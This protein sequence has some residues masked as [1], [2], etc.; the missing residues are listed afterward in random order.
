MERE[1]EKL[2]PSMLKNSVLCAIVARKYDQYNKEVPL[3]A[4]P[5]LLAS[6]L[7]N[8]AI[9]IETAVHNALRLGVTCK[10]LNP[11]YLGTLL[12]TYPIEDRNAVMT[13]L[14]R[15]LQ[16]GY[17]C[18]RNALQLLIHAQ[19]Q[20]NVQDPE[21]CY[22]HSTLLYQASCHNDDKMVQLLFTFGADPHENFQGNP[23]FWSAKN[24]R[25][26]QLFIAQGIDLHTCGNNNTN[27]LWE[28]VWKWDAD[29]DLMKFYLEREVN[30]RLLDQD[31]GGSILHHVI[32][33][34]NIS[35]N[36]SIDTRMSKIKLLLST[37]PDMVNVR[38]KARKTPLDCARQ[39]E[40]SQEVI[41]LFRKHGA[42]TS[43]ELEQE[44]KTYVPS[45]D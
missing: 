39:T 4:L 16:C 27:V 25:M 3:V 26:L 40:H 30:P 20:P 6:V 28:L 36:H 38:D 19:A 44:H 2:V 15:Y 14:Q 1:P 9:P 12:R 34:S 32:K 43:A 13:K 35:A 10:R 21:F 29:I 24:S 41:A 42:R 11:A 17:A 31:H 8:Q 45:Y 33:W 18:K 22:Q 23:T 37:I 5:D 7:T